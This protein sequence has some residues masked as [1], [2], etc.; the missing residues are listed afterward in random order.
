MKNRA[1]K[2]RNLWLMTKKVIRNF[3]GRKSEIFREKVKFGKFFTESEIFSETEGK[4]ETW[5][6]CIIASGRMDASACEEEDDNS[7]LVPC[8]KKTAKVKSIDR[9]HESMIHH[10]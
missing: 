2:F 3:G 10:I 4:S 9:L 8:S 6:K 5:G 1:K 7:E